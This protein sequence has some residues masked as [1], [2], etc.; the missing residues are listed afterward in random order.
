MNKS[1]IKGEIKRIKGKVNEEIGHATNSPS[2]EGKGIL[3]QIGGTI[4]KGVGDLKD[5]IK[6]KTDRLLDRKPGKR[7]T[8]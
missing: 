8:A 5:K 1:H 7:G 3:Q 4:E 2:Q 6:E